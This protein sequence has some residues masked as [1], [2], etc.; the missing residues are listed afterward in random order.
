[1]VVSLNVFFFWKI[2]LFSR[3][4][5]F[6][7]PL[8]SLQRL[9]EI[10][11]MD[12]NVPNWRII[13]KRFHPRAFWSIKRYFTLKF[14]KQ[15]IWI[16]IAKLKILDCFTETLFCYWIYLIYAVCKQTAYTNVFYLLLIMYFV[17][18]RSCP[19]RLYLCASYQQP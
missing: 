3:Y 9:F 13:H 15:K 2:V 5:K 7:Q 4:C 11:F 17:G 6:G 8:L 10:S 14:Q 19:Q 1:M 12:P 16:N 18:C